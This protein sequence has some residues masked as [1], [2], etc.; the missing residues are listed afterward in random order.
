MQENTS[1]RFSRRAFF[2]AAAGAAA[3]AALLS[4][5]QDVFARPTILALPDTIALENCP[6]DAWETANRSEL[7]KHAYQQVLQSA[8]KIKDGSLRTTVVNIIKN[9]APTIMEQ[10]TNMAAV[11]RVYNRLLD[12]HL[13]EEGKISRETLFPRVADIQ[14]SP[15]PFISAPGSGYGSHHAYPGGLPAHMATNL[16]I[17]EGLLETYRQNFAYDL[18]SDV[19]LASEALHDL[20][21]P[22]VFQWEENGVCLPEYTIAGTGAHHILSLAES[23]YR[24]LPAEVIVAQACAHNHPGTARDEADV[25]GWL[26]AAAIIAGQDA[27]SFLSDDGMH[28]PQPQSQAGYFTHLADH[29]WVL[30][31]PAAQRSVAA[32]QKIAREEY[33]MSEEDIK[34]RK[35]N[36]FRNYIGAQLSFMHLNYMMSSGQEQKA[37]AM[38][39]TLVK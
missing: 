31:S 22:W 29:D 30:S 9:P 1:H 34:G 13:I 21:K 5:H 26:Q 36:Y 3:G 25:V 23:M 38:I 39:R 35:F 18:D 16:L 33:K 15:Q 7:V 27:A 10:Y 17:A 12:K 14:K 2:K 6:A 11:E 20:H 28:L 19:V 32:L 24:K 37:I 8:G 4:F